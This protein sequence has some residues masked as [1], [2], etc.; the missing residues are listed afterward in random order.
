MIE[1]KVIY[2]LRQVVYDTGITAAA[3]V[4]LLAAEDIDAMTNYDAANEKEVMR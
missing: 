2:N 1:P 4:D 3:A